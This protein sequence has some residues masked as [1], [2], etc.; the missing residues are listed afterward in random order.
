[1][2]LLI[3][4]FSLCLVADKGFFSLC[5]VDSTDKIH[6]GSAL[7]FVV[8]APQIKRDVPPSENDDISA[9][10]EAQFERKGFIFSADELSGLVDKTA[11]KLFTKK[12]A[13][14]NSAETKEIYETVCESV[15]TVATAMR[16]GRIDT[17][18]T[19]VNANSTCK[20]CSYKNICRKNNLQGDED[21][22]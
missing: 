4:L 12:L 3:Y 11:D 8:N 20:Y 18:E 7:Y 1:M 2:Q 16:S 22:A 5:G 15:K 9:M 21:N 14:K 19:N 10:A 13:A 6:P 17:L